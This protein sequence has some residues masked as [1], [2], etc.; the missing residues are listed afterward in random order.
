MKKTI[1]LF[2]LMTL[3]SNFSFAQKDSTATIEVV[4]FAVKEISPDYII[5][6]FELSE[7]NSETKQTRAIAE[8]E[9][10]L[11]E[12]LKELEIND[13]E[14]KFDNFG[15]DKV[16]K[17]K[18]VDVYDSKWYLLKLTNINK[19]MTFNSR[20]NALNVNKFTID[21][22]K[23]SQIDTFKKELYLEA[24]NNA[25]EKAEI[26]LSVLKKKVGN[27]LEIKEN[28]SS[29]DYDP[30]KIDNSTKRE[31]VRDG[32][33]GATDITLGNLRLKYKVIVKFEIIN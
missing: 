25:K 22:L 29:Y 27:P 32:Y 2:I 10:E 13:K 6:S 1:T 7:Y 5:V 15:K 17:K 11:F 8:Q 21:E 28:P 26:L 9:N 31:I 14:L 23:N 18:A 20:L 3:L 4:G 30:V 19:L 24:M 33:T 16:Y 12:I